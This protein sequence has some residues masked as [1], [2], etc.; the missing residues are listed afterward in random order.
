[1]HPEHAGGQ[2]TDPGQGPPLVLPPGGLRPG[3]QRAVQAGQLILAQP[4]PRRRPPRGQARRAACVPGLPSP[5]HRPLADP[6]LSGNVR[7][8]HPLLEPF[9][10]R[11]PDLLTPRAVLSS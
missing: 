8:G 11:Q 4:A 9:H 1:V 3:V 6:Q 7:S 5:P 2:V 10:D